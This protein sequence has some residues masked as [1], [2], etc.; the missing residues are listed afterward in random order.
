V[1]T[2]RPPKQDILPFQASMDDSPTP[3]FRELL[4][5][6]R[7][8]LP[9]PTDFKVDLEASH[10]KSLWEKI[11]KLRRYSFGEFIHAGGSGMVFRVK[12]RGGETDWALKI[13]RKK[14]FEPS[15]K[16]GQ[17][18]SPFSDAEISALQQVS[19]PFVVTLRDRITS[20]D[21]VIGLVTTYVPDPQ[22]LDEYLRKTFARDPDP[23]RK[24]GIPCPRNS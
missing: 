3:N 14:T 16:T 8:E 17:R 12:E 11:P 21:G 19:H 6:P 2:K 20:D 24:R 4:L 15:P 18:E 5:R 9:L 22:P 10:L 13:A 23:N 1:K 7:I